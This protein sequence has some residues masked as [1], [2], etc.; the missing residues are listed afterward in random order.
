MARQALECLNE[1]SPPAHASG[2]VG[3]AYF[4]KDSKQSTNS[5]KNC[6]PLQ[7]L[8]PC[9]LWMDVRASRQAA[10]VLA[11]GDAA[12]QVNGGGQGP[13]SAEWMIPKALW[14]KE[15]EPAVF[16]K[17]RWI[18]EYQVLSRVTNA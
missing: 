8:R 9:L 4:T 6:P 7:A 17:A 13:V 10:R 16:E 5:P 1:R 14:I 2:E 12:L 3:G 15:N 18:C 11:T